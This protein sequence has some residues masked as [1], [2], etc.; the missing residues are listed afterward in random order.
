MR[1]HGIRLSIPRRN[2]FPS[3]SICHGYVF[4][5]SRMSEFGRG[6][7]MQGAVIERASHEADQERA[8][9][10]RTLPSPCDERLRRAPNS[11]MVALSGRWR[12][13]PTLPTL[14]VTPSKRP[15]VDVFGGLSDGGARLHPG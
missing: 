4:W 6:V 2:N 9:A 7:V 12:S 1:D 13:H 10:L 5:S 15:R 3:G 8:F 14:C 11:L